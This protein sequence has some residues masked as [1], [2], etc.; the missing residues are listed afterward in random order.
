MQILTRL[1]RSW[2]VAR[3]GAWIWMLYKVPDFFRWAL[4]RPAPDD[5]TATHQRAA[6][7][8]LTAALDLRGVAKVRPFCAIA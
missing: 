8:I 7:S 6:R 1:W 3:T 5:R 2:R 4:R